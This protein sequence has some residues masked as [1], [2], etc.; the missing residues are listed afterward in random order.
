M[1]IESA[2]VNVVFQTLALGSA[3]NTV[4]NYLFNFNLLGQIQA[5]SIHSVTGFESANIFRTGVRDAIDHLPGRA[6]E[7]VG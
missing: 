2:G 7:G 4:L 3:Q 6:R 5:S 1:I